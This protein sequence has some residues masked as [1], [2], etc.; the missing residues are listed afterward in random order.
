MLFIFS[1]VRTRAFS[2]RVFLY[3]QSEQRVSNNMRHSA[4]R[5][6]KGICTPPTRTEH[7]DRVL[8]L[9]SSWDAANFTFV[10][11]SDMIILL[12]FTLNRVY[13]PHFHTCWLIYLDL[14]CSYEWVSSTTALVQWYVVAKR[15]FAICSICFLNFFKMAPLLL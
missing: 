7:L 11:I 8:K 15:R 6:G 9:P 4:T 2:P 1:C 14:L 5:L 3:R 12:F 10:C 13:Y